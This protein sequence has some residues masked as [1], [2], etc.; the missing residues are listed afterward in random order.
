MRLATTGRALLFAVSLLSGSASISVADEAW[1][2][3]SGSMEADDTDSQARCL[4]AESEMDGN[5]RGIP[6]FEIGACLSGDVKFICLANKGH[7]REQAYREK[8]TLLKNEIRDAWFEKKTINMIG[9]SHGAV[10]VLRVMQ[11]LAPEGIRVATVISLDPVLYAYPPKLRPKTVKE[12]GRLKMKVPEQALA[13][14]ATFL[15]LYQRWLAPPILSPIHGDNLIGASVENRNITKQARAS[16][17]QQNIGGFLHLAF[18]SLQ[19]VRDRIA[20][21]LSRANLSGQWMVCVGCLPLSGTDT[22]CS[23]H[24]GTCACDTFSLDFPCAPS[25]ACGIGSAAPFVTVID[26]RV[27]GFYRD[28]SGGV[29]YTWDLDGTLNSG[30]ADL[31]LLSEI[32]IDLGGGMI[33]EQ[34][35]SSHILG[36]I[37]SCEFQG[38]TTRCVVGTMEM[39]G[40]FLNTYP[41]ACAPGISD[42]SGSGDVTVYIYPMK[43]TGFCP[44]IAP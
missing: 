22:V 32:V 30:Q 17:K 10:M 36:S 1:F 8:Q 44:R 21:L 37:D 38:K 15:N 31:V 14:K 11:E 4:E 35:Y 29:S 28:A 33:T 18:P 7:D 20:D 6:P 40:H 12:D 41:G 39:S 2:V 24:T 27:N 42:V 5:P 43:A 25:G 19:V 26:G 13:K 9:Y 16:A 34:F 23:D 3:V